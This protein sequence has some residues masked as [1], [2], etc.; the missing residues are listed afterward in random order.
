MKAKYN[1]LKGFI[2]A[3]DTIFVIPVYQRNYDWKKDNCKQLFDD[4]RKI[5][6]NNKTHFIGTICHKMDGRN[7]SVII[8][9]QQRIT[10]VMLLLKALCDVSQSSVLK[11]KISKQ[12]LINEFA[13]S[14][15]YRIKLKPIKKDEKVY[16][17]LIRYDTF[18]ESDFSDYEKT[19]NIYKNYS[20]FK[21]LI[22]S[23][24][25][26]GILDSEIEEA[27]ERLEFVELELEDKENPQEIF[28]SLNS[29]GLD[30][31]NTDLLRNYLLMSLDYKD[32]EELYT[33]FWM[34]IEN[35]V[36]CDNMELFMTHYLLLKRKSSSI[37]Y[38]NK[39]A[40]LSSRN[41]YYT[42]KKDFPNLKND[43]KDV[44]EDL[45]KEMYKYAK[46]YKN[47]IFDD[48]SNPS[49]E[50]SKRLYS[51]FYCLEEK[52]SAILVMY[53]YEKYDNS[54]ID[55]TTFIKILD[56]IISFV[57]R[58]DV[59]NHTGIN[60]QFATL[61]IQRIDEGMNS[62]EI[63]TA[64]ENKKYNLFINLIW[65]VLTAGK[66]S[67]SF[68]KDEEFKS[69]L[70]T[71]DLYNSLKSKKCKY[72]LYSIELYSNKK[73]CPSFQ[74]GTIEHICP[75]TLSKEW[76]DYLNSKFDLQ[77][78]DKFVH[79]LGNLTLSA[80]NAEMSNNLFYLKQEQYSVSSYFY[81]RDLKN[82]NDWTSK[83]VEQ[84]GKKLSSIALNIWSLPNEYNKKS[85]VDTGITYNLDSEVSL[86]TGTKPDTVSIM[87]TEKQITNWTDFVGEITKA[88]FIL[89]KE[90]FLELL[91]Y[92]DFPGNKKYIDTSCKYMKRYE[93][94]DR[95][96]YI[97]VNNSVETNIKIVKKIVDYFDSRTDTSI[98]DEIWFT[99]R[100]T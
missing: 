36:G 22:K 91:A 25:E 11:S 13:Q 83:Q 3:S 94:I 96:L 8:D 24:I 84:R 92:S 23:E 72:L 41:L 75:N 98:K 31:T 29:T 47:F 87:G 56:A 82:Y 50:L 10:S 26:K 61:S 93:E 80:Y 33:K 51:L 43:N 58:S 18:D 67:S 21:E 7:K 59:C 28:E 65:S 48:N 38:E 14:D 42:F 35:M 9:G 4:I 15:E 40:Q 17:K 88:L 79:T 60:K 77:N 34:E 70:E 20:Y 62:K 45:F 71:R 78:Y 54:I 97:D 32:Q 52:D 1:F 86:F 69:K 90:I 16:Q 100:R 5:I 85:T 76:K 44:I 27:V 39:K 6:K 95:D 37:I 64:L 49:N 19:S 12:F 55:E 66:G 57:M 74:T 53:L 30:L 81:T 63:K 99:L 89:D 68:P 2:T 73:E 46:Y